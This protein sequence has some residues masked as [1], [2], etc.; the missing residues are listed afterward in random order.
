M[1]HKDTFAPFRPKARLRPVFPA[2]FDFTRFGP[3]R[4]RLF[5]APPPCETICGVGFTLR[6][7]YLLLMIVINFDSCK[8]IP[9]R[10]GKGL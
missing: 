1:R 10:S 4:Q 3:F 7:T 2:R 5:S 8:P 6:F 9:Q